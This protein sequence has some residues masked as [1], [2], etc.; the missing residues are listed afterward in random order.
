MVLIMYELVKMLKLNDCHM[1][2]AICTFLGSSV[3][4]KLL[5]IIL[6]LNTLFRCSG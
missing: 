2:Y 6:N 3:C 1:L 5:I 4:M